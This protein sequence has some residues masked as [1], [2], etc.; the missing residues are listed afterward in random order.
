MA[1]NLTTTNLEEIKALAEELL[2][3]ADSAE[4]VDEKK[5]IEADLEQTVNYYTAVSKSN[6]Y[7]E[8]KASGNPMEFAVLKFF[9]PTIKVKETEDK[10]TKAVFRSIEPATKP[11]DL[12]NM[13]QKLGGIGAD[14]KWFDAL[15]KFNYYLTIRA[16]ERVGAKV[17]SDALIISDVAKSIDMGK[18]PCSNTQL[19]KT[20]QGIV[21]MMLGGDYKANSHDV[22]YLVDVYANDNKKSK[23][24]ITLANH[25]TLAG[26]LK[27]VCGRIL[28]NGTGYDVVQREIKED[29]KA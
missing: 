29:K 24:S 6:C 10:E 27:K 19:L 21:T 9:F 25:R 1:V 28:T 13:H 26:Y 7:S 3:K 22:N 16:A 17:K 23:T 18:N 11:I 4:N 12:V 14:T 5:S 15:Q 2:E 8:A 20:L